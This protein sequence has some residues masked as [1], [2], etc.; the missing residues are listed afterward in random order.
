MATL[1][2]HRRGQ[3]HLAF[4]FLVGGI[5]LLIALTTALLTLSFLSSSYGYQSS[6]RALVAANAGVEDGYLQLTRNKDFAPSRY[7]FPVGSYTATVTVTQNSPAV[8]QVTIIGSS[9]VSNYT[10]AVKAVVAVDASTSVMSVLTWSE[11]VL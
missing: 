2:N 3:A 11:L 8:G 5:V 1:P 10:R 9:T 4:V 6:N 7:V